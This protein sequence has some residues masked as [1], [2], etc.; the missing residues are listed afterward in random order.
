[1]KPARFGLS[2][3][4]HCCRLFW[5]VSEVMNF[6]TRIPPRDILILQLTFPIDSA[7]EDSYV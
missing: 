7:K 3:R 5:L 6:E 4:R 2:G 1:M